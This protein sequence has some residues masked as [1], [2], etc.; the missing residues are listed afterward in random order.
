MLARSRGVVGDHGERAL[1]GDRQPEVVG[2]IG[3]LGDDGLGGHAVDERPGRRGI[4]GLAGGEHEGHRTAQAAHGEMDLVGQAAAR[5]SDGLIASPPFAPPEC[6]WARTMVESTIKYS[7][8]GSSDTA[9]KMRRPT[10]LPLHRL[11]RRKTLFHSPNASGRPRHGEPVRT[12]HNTP[13]TNIRV[14]RPVE[15]RG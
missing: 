3:G 8:S 15:P 11:K 7:K 13:S 9:S 5:A 10:P 1:A 12:I 2:D 4:T 6:W 14:S